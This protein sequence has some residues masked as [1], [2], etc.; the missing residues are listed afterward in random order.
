MK[1][2]VQLELDDWIPLDNTHNKEE[3][4]PAGYE[5]NQP[6]SIHLRHILEDELE[7]MLD[8]NRFVFSDDGKLFHIWCT[9]CEHIPCVWEA[10]QQSMIMT[11]MPPCTMHSTGR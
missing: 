2:T 4:L 5:D 6:E 11:K 3:V 8:N 1:Q 7:M 9:H 10:N